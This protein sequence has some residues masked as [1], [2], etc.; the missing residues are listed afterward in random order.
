MQHAFL[1]QAPGRPVHGA[2]ADPQR[3][4]RDQVA[5][6]Q[7]RV[8]AF[9]CYLLG[10][11]DEAADVT[12]EVLIRLWRHRERVDETRMLPWLLRVTRNACIDALRR[13]RVQPAQA[14]RSDVLEL[15]ATDAPSPADAAEQ[16]DFQV[17][18][19]QALDRLHEPYRSIVLLREVQELKY[20]EISEALELPLGTV[21]VYLHRARKMLREALKEVTNRETV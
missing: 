21:K 5:R 4:F 16:L 13:R 11:A 1:E 12:Q 7:H 6:F 9:A 2:A 19:Q 15:T 14:G 10:D 17:R 18:L 8:Y 3:R 20:E